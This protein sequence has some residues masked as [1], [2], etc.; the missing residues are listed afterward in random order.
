MFQIKLNYG[1]PNNFITK[2]LVL[3]LV[4]AFDFFKLKDRDPLIVMFASQYTRYH[5]MRWQK[6]CGEPC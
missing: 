1:F 5:I 2:V 4:L 3:M 6:I